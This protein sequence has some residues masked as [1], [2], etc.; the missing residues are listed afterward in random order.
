MRIFPIHVI[1]IFLNQGTITGQIG[2]QIKDF[3]AYYKLPP[4]VGFHIIGCEEETFVS[5]FSVICEDKCEETV[6]GFNVSR[7]VPDYG[8]QGFSILGE[9]PEDTVQ[10]FSVTRKE[11]AV[12]A[13]GFSVSSEE[14]SDTIR[15][16]S[17]TYEISDPAV[18][19]FIVEGR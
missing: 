16:F 10:G 18:V 9:D 3:D 17:V 19:G 6:T 2:A 7:K 13:V 4:A 11:E 12:G 8:V 14:E 15:C 1:P 5:G